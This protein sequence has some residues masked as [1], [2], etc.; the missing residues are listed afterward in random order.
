MDKLDLKVNRI[1]QDAKDNDIDVSFEFNRN[2]NILGSYQDIINKRKEFAHL[3]DLVRNLEKEY[4]ELIKNKAFDDIDELLKQRDGSNLVIKLENADKDS[5]K[6]LADRLMDKLGKGFVFI[7]NVSNN[8]VTFIAKSNTNIHAGKIAKEAA[9]ITGGNGG[10]RPDMA[11]AGG[12]DITKVD[13]ALLKV[14]ELIK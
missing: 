13:D 7:A 10:G 4:K 5:L 2:E 6:P 14:R 1:L 9:I 3:G 8:K 12:K 11:Q